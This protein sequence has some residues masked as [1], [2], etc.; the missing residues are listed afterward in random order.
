MLEASH[1]DNTGDGPAVSKP[2]ARARRPKRRASEVTIESVDGH[3]GALSKAPTSVKKA[4]ITKEKKEKVVKEK[5]EQTLQIKVEKSDDQSIPA[6][7][8]SATPLKRARTATTKGASTNTEDSDFDATTGTLNRVPDF[9]DD[10]MGEQDVDFEFQDTGLADAA[11]LKSA[12]VPKTKPEPKAK[13]ARS[14]PTKIKTEK[15][16][17]IKTE[18]DKAT[19]DAKDAGVKAG[20]KEKKDKVEAVTGDAA[21]KLLLDYLTQQNRP[22]NGTD[23]ITNLHGKVKKTLADKLLQEMAANGQIMGKHT[24]KSWIFWCIQ[25]AEDAAKPE[26]LAVLDTTISKLRESIPVLKSTSKNLTT[27]LQAL[28]AMPTISELRSRLHAL[29]A[30]RTAKQDKLQAFREG[31]V[32]K[33]E[34]AEMERVEAQWTYW[35][36]KAAVRKRCFEDIEYE[37]LA[38]MSKEDIWDKYDRNLATK[39]A[40]QLMVSR[41]GIEDEDE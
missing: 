41:A 31:K 22:Y 7:V 12:P 4:R 6:D 21:V 17:K 13:A 20:P 40:L 26:E 18:K 10:G 36:R 3:G 9:G 25:N 5:K 14:K 35:S 16:V 34:T 29:E 27:Q 32:Q 33:I 23:I 38:G 19:K 2:A 28:K 39:R 11:D 1:A 30:D 37:L 8:G 24:G 15:P